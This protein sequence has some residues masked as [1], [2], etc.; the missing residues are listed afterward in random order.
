MAE[1]WT[2]GN[3]HEV[4][5]HI[6]KTYISITGVNQA[7][8][9]GLYIPGRLYKLS[10]TFEAERSVP[11]TRFREARQVFVLVQGAYAQQTSSTLRLGD[12]DGVADAAVREPTVVTSVQTCSPRCEQMTGRRQNRV[13]RFTLFSG[14][15]QSQLF[16]DG[17]RVKDLTF[18]RGRDKI[19]KC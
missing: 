7:D 9:G 13:V 6:L 14:L 3:H 2:D 19:F 4:Y 10:P 17:R 15:L 16:T 1:K 11:F 12:G 18:R 5:F 8:T